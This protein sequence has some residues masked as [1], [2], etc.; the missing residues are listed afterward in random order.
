[1]EILSPAATLEGAAEHAVLLELEVQ[2]LREQVA[3]LQAERATLRWAIEHDELTGLANRRLFN[4][5]A[6]SLLRQYQRCAVLVLDLNE[7][8]PINDRYGHAVGDEVLCVVAQRMAACLGGDLTV[9]LGGDEFA[10]ILTESSIGDLPDWHA[11][12]ASLARQI[13]EP[14]RLTGETLTV[15][16]SIG[17][18]KGAGDATAAGE[19]LRRADHAMYHA[20]TGGRPYAMWDTH[21]P[22]RP[23]PPH[24]S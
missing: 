18:A 10:A 1:M 19:L 22:A 2:R 5:V 9:R 7:F 16:A 3:R 4:A 14:M 15:T 11:R 21:L 20:K 23:G 24:R 6:P 12:A 17:I 8:K 13:A